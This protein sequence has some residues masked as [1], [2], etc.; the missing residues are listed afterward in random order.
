MSHCC[1]A[2]DIKAGR[3]LQVEVL[4]HLIIAR[5]AWASMRDQGLGW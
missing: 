3:L 4:D 5:G 1:A 2:I